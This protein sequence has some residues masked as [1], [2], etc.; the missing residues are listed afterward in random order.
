MSRRPAPPASRRPSEELEGFQRTK[1]L[2]PGQ[3]Q[4]I[5]LSVAISD[6]SRWDEKLL[7]QV[8]VDGGYQFKVGPDSAHS[9][10]SQTRRR[11]T[12]RSPLRSAT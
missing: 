6:L 8:V 9:F 1:A 5:T 2:A 7:K 10:D 4:H 11:S 12:A 3:T